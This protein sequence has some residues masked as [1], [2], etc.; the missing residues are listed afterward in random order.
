[1]PI[2]T[3]TP[4]GVI[5]DNE[6]VFLILI[7]SYH[8]FFLSFFFVERT[9]VADGSSHALNDQTHDHVMKSVGMG[10]YDLQDVSASRSEKSA[11]NIPMT[12]TR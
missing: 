4:F 8:F 1:M 11:N 3:P 7:F 10:S 9:S 5:V 6:K 2:A 12:D